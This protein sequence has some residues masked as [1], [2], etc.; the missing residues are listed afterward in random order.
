MPPT[1]LE[2]Y[3]IN[4]LSKLSSTLPIESYGH[5]EWVEKT[6]CFEGKEYLICAFLKI[7]SL[8]HHLEIYGHQCL[9]MN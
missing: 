3:S 2:I 7:D 1:D 6:I 4:A 5:E 9:I 8:T